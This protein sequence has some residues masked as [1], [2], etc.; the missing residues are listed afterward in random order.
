MLVAHISDFHILAAPALCYGFSDTRKGLARAVTALASLDPRPDLVVATGDLVDEATP[1]AYATLRRILQDLHLPLVL[2]PGN[3]DDRTLLAATFPDHDYLIGSDG[4]ACFVRDYKAF[5][6]VA[7]D[8][9]IS[10]R[11]YADPCDA[12]LAWLERTLVS[13][14]ERPTMLVMHHPPV[15]TGIAFMDAIQPPHFGALQAILRDHAQ[16]RLVLCG[17][18]HRNLDAVIGHARVAAAGSTAHQFRLLTDLEAPPTVTDEPA[19]IRLHLWRA[20]EVV[21][22][23][24]PVE[25]GFSTGQFMGMNAE[26]WREVSAALR[27]GQG[28]GAAAPDASIDP[29][30]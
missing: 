26:R 23:I 20:G 24:T 8:A 6:L 29:T 12:A 9:V 15:S 25:R 11:E 30:T 10:G 1:D 5:R 22:F 21:S 4:L 18:V 17:H 14:P 19:A 28:R 7:F 27:A 2:I 16:V 3:H 13:Q